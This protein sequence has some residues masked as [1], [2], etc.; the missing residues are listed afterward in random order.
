MH[1]STL[2]PDYFQL[3]KFNLDFNECSGGGE[4]SL[5]N[6]GVSQAYCAKFNTS[7]WKEI[8]Y[9]A[10]IK[11]MG[12]FFFFSSRFERLILFSRTKYFYKWTGLWLI[13]MEINHPEPSLSISDF[14]LRITVGNVYPMAPDQVLK[15]LWSSASLFS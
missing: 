10:L 14:K 11:S 15:I 4:Q 7:E 2:F 1:I 5:S 3:L 13:K 6:Y 9:G 8:Y 12:F